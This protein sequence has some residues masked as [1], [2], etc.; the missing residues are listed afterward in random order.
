[1][2]VFSFSDRLLATSGPDV[3]GDPAMETPVERARPAVADQP[4]AAARAETTKINTVI[5]S[6]GVYLPP[7]E[8][9]SKEI[10]KGCN[11]RMW[12]PLEKMTGI[13]SRRMAGETEFAIDLAEKAITRC[14][15]CSRHDCD[16]IDLLIACNIVRM[17]KL[18]TISVEPNTTLKLKKRFGFKNAIAFDITNAC[19]GMFTAMQVAQAY[20]TTGTARRAMVVSGEFI[21]DITRTAQ[22]EI[23]EFMDPR[24]AC[25]TVGDAGAAIV[26]EAAASNDVGFHELEVYSLSKYSRMCIGRLTE[27]PHGGPIMHVPDPLEH[28]AVAVKHSVMH[29]QY[30]L[31][32]SPWSPEMIHQLIMHQTSDRSIREG[33]R[34]INKAFKKKICHDGNT[35]N[36][37]AHRGNTASTSHMVAVWDN[38]HNGRIKSGDNVVFGITGSGQTIGTGIYTFDD[39]PDRLRRHAAAPQPAPPAAVPAPPPL[40]PAT[41][42]VRIHSCGTAAADEGI[43]ATTLALTTAAGERCLAASDYDR[44]DIELLFFT[45]V[46][47]TG[48]ICEPAIATLIASEM[49]I[50]EIIESEYD[51]KTFAFDVYNGALGLLNGC[52]VA[53]QMVQSGLYR[54]AMVV[55][56][57][58]EQ[59]ETTFPENPLGFRE[60]ASALI[61]DR[62][63]GQRVGFGNFE[64]GYFTELQDARVGLGYY[65]DGK[66]CYDL[67]EDEAIDDYYLECIRPTVA[68][69]LDREGL[70]ISEIRL[71]LPPQF[72]A[73]FNRRLATVLK[74]DPAAVVDIARDDQD[75]FTSSL[76]FSLE[77]AQQ[78]GLAQPGDIGL[79]VNVASGLQIGTAV[80]YF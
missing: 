26:L 78:R 47:R 12:F 1:V 50:N 59:N 69:L 27:Q 44:S 45:G 25:L 61:L 41:R 79:I 35:I 39:L 32:K 5:E 60:A 74:I 24:L 68:K 67:R 34:T 20:I 40:P 3:S 14:L 36:N 58:I 52:Q 9:S 49:G 71:V 2:G 65:R 80:Y 16:D 22:K 76:P 73:D 6:L 75:L 23:C 77:H 62:S 37:L 31:E 42:Q 28:T 43:E 33:K 18:N 72:S 17:D 54:T 70:D 7:K 64:F 63:Q 4:H 53:A 19:T 13:K 38:I 30:M 66:P 10:L 11:K 21:T 48:L 29:A 51:K 55:A 46:T 8:V 56:A 57:E 15:E